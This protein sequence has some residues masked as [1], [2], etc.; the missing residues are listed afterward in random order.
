MLF[1]NTVNYH[2]QVVVD[3]TELKMC[4]QFYIYSKRLGVRIA[5][6]I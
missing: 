2:K 5:P 1:V 6:L 3:K 4:S